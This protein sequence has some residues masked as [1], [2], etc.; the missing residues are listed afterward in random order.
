MVVNVMAAKESLYADQFLRSL[1][2]ENLSDRTVEKYLEAVGL[3][4]DFLVSKGMPT[5]PSALTREHVEAF[6]EAGLLSGLMEPY[7]G[8]KGAL[9]IVLPEDQPTHPIALRRFRNWFSF[10][11]RQLMDTAAAGG[12]LPRRNVCKRC[13][14]PLC[15]SKNPR[16]PKE[17]CSKQENPE[18]YRAWRKEGV[19]RARERG[20]T[21]D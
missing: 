11:E 19:Y 5:Q 3:F 15:P 8:T 2:A 21:A 9:E 10:I 13:G 6:I 17:Y 12:R 7:T 20:V 14:S 4:A 16:R 18:R 1:R